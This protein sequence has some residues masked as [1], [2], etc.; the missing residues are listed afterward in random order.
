KW[1][2]PPRQTLKVNCDAAVSENR[3]DVGAGMVVRDVQGNVLLAAA[4]TVEHI[5]DPRSIEAMAIL[6]ALKVSL[7]K[8]WRKIIVESDAENVLNEINAY[9]PSLSLYGNVV[10][11]IKS[12]VSP[13]IFCQFS[14]ISKVGNKMAH[15]LARLASSVYTN[16]VWIESFCL[17]YHILKNLFPLYHA[18]QTISHVTTPNL[19]FHFKPAVFFLS[20]S[21]TLSL[22]HNFSFPL[23]YS[24]SPAISLSPSFF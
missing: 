7:E 8:G 23:T 4:M 14:W 22:F 19:T 17:K 24:L 9:Q 18:L 21:L 5:R 11:E 6:H 10:E 12:L 16:M 15:E 2:P 13:F 1:C 3:N 20:L